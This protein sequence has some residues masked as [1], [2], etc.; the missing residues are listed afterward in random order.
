V[1]PS[2]P[3]QILTIVLLTYVSAV[4]VIDLRSRRIPNGL[5][6]VAA[7]AGLALNGLGGGFTGLASAG[8]GLA[9]ALLAFL[10]M[11][12]GGGLG[13]GDVKA[14]AA[15]GALVGVPGIFITVGFTLIGGAIA[16]VAILILAGELVPA[17]Q[18]LHA[19]LLLAK[20]GG[21]VGSIRPAAGEM[22]ARRFPYGLAIAGGVC[23]A[24]WWMGRLQA[25][26]TGGMQ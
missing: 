1:I 9:I 25:L 5:S 2:D 21:P 20:A 24:S 11:Y 17:V 8:L 26:V 15:V 7:V 23:A 18:R 10:P 16:A 14:M 4:A 13:A 6:L 3:Q 22:A 19:N 12:A